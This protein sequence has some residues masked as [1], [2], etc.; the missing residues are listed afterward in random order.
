MAHFDLPSE[1]TVIDVDAF[2]NENCDVL[3]MNKENMR[4]FY[5]V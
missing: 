1:D 5:P 3:A 4:G 2:R